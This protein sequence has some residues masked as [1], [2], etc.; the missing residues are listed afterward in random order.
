MSL[1]L[2]WLVFPALSLLVL[3]GCGLLVA[4]LAG[5]RPPLGVLLGLGLCVVIVDAKNEVWIS[6]RLRDKVRKE[7]APTDG[8]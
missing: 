2:A 6:E 3:W 5:D 1:P 8:I 7:R 4:H